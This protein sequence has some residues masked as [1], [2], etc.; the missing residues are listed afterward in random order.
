SAEAPDWDLWDIRGLA[1]EVTERLVPDGGRVEPLAGP[2]DRL[3]LP[4]VFVPG[5]VLALRSGERLLG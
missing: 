3:A 1:E 2:T 5:T 4:D